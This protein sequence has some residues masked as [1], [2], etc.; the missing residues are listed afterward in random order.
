MGFPLL[1]EMPLNIHNL[2]CVYVQGVKT[3]GDLVQV[4]G[5]GTES[6]GPLQVKASFRYNPKLLCDI[7]ICKMNITISFA[8]SFY[9]LVEI[10][11]MKIIS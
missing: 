4:H 10:S 1:I 8:A 11:S 9:A 7:S 2:E 6:K 3:G 5:A